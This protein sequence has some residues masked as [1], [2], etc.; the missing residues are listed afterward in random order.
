MEKPKFYITTPIYYPS[1]NMTIGHTYTTVAADSMTRFK[2]MTGYDTYFLTG[3][4]EHGQKIAVFYV[5]RLL[6]FHT[7]GRFRENLGIGVDMVG[8]GGL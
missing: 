8:L 2:K 1:G 6:R 7:S 3:T 5:L 4:D